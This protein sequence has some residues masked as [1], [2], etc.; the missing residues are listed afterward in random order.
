MLRGKEL[1]GRKDRSRI[2]PLRSP[3]G[4]AQ[5]LGVEEV[6]GKVIACISEGQYQLTVRDPRTWYQKPERA[7]SEH[8]VTGADKQQ[9]IR[10]AI[11]FGWTHELSDAVMNNLDFTEEKHASLVKEIQGSAMNYHTHAL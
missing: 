7:I 2:P 10:E 8:T 1:P 5:S 11:S 9:N 3:N 4:H 6:N